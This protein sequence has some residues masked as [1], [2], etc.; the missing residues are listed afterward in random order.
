MSGIEV[1]LNVL[2]SL[3]IACCVC[4]LVHRLVLQPGL[5]GLEMVSI[6][7]SQ[8]A[9]KVLPPAMRD[10]SEHNLDQAMTT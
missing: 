3:Q 7:D 8:A 6:K 4:S 5:Q 10:Q 2:V 1:I 9:A